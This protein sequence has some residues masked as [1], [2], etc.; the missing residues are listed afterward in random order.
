ML[1]E[2][3]V[4]QSTFK[5]CEDRAAICFKLGAVEGSPNTVMH[6]EWRIAASKRLNKKK[7]AINCIS[8]W[9]YVTEVT[10]IKTLVFVVQ[11]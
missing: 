4:S 11:N 5:R 7:V 10:R 6:V 9:P 8:K 1:M 2:L 3:T